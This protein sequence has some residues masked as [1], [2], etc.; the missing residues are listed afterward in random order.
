MSFRHTGFF[1]TQ[2]RDVISRKNFTTCKIILVADKCVFV[3]QASP[4]IPNVADFVPC[5]AG[6]VILTT[7]AVRRWRDLAIY[8]L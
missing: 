7:L 3:W 5:K 6:K 8:S 4:E 1:G 2:G